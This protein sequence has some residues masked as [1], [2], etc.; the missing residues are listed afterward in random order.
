M[1]ILPIHIL[2]YTTNAC[3][4]VPGMKGDNI[5][6]ATDSVEVHFNS[7]TLSEA[8]TSHRHAHDPQLHAYQML[9]H[10]CC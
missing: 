9:Q 1:N 2:Y 6:T 3:V 10:T 8:K 4:H 5:K 7:I